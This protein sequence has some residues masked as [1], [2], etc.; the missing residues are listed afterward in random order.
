MKKNREV[1]RRWMRGTLDRLRE[2][3]QGAEEELISMMS[4]LDRG[5]LVWTG[6]QPF[7]WPKGK[8]RR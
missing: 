1:V 5:E 2:H 8:R 4:K 6:P 7:G 3:T